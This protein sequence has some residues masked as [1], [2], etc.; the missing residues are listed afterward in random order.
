MPLRGGAVQRRGTS[1]RAR[2]SA[3]APS[4]SGA[5]P[6]HARARTASRASTST[7][8]SSSRLTLSSLPRRAARHSGVAPSCARG[9]LRQRGKHGADAAAAAGTRMQPCRARRSPRRASAASAVRSG[10]TTPPALECTRLARAVPH[11]AALCNH[12]VPSARVRRARFPTVTVAIGR[13]LARTARAWSAASTCAPCASSRLSRLVRRASLH[14]LP[15]A[16]NSG[17]LPRCVTRRRARAASER[18]GARAAGAATTPPAATR[19]L[20]RAS[21]SAP[22]CSSNVTQ[23]TLP[24]AT[25]SCSGVHPHCKQR[26]GVS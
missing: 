14:S 18:R 2:R 17:V 5:H 7:P 11:S 1:L 24:R 22:R 13:L 3:S 8:C 20:S 6:P 23:A 26:R 19:T 12:P 4:D 15:A 16:T 9:G 25:A 21:T 10:R